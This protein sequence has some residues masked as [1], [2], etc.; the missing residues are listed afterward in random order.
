MEGRILKLPSINCKLNFLTVIFFLW[1]YF[2]LFGINGNSF[3]FGKFFRGALLI[4]IWKYKFID[5]IWTGKFHGHY[6]R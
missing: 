5:V 6:C 2:L 4:S 1:F 3:L